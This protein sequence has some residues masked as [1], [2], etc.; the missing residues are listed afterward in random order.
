MAVSAISTPQQMTFANNPIY[1]VVD[2][3]NKGLDGFRYVVDIYYTGTSNKI[4]E[5]LIA[6]RPTDGYGEFNINQIVKNLLSQ[7]LTISNTTSHAIPNL[8][9]G[10]DVK[11]GEAYVTSWTFN[12]VEPNGA[13]ARLVQDPTS[14]A[15]S[16][17]TGDQLRVVTSPTNSTVDGLRTVL[18]RTSYTVTINAP[19]N[20]TA[21]GGLT[22]FAD[23]TKTV[24]RD[25]YTFTNLR[26]Y[27]GALDRVSFINYDDDDYT[28]STSLLGKFLTTIPRGG[29]TLSANSLCWLN[30]FA[31]SLSTSGNRVYFENSNGDVFY[32]ASG[33]GGI[34]FGAFN[35][36]HGNLPTLTTSSGTAPLIKTDTI[37]YEVWLATSGGVRTSEKIRINLSE[38]CNISDCE[39]LFMDKL[40]SFVSFPMPLRVEQ[41]G[42]VQRKVFERALPTTYTSLDGGKEVYNIEEQRRFKLNTQYLN[43]GESKYFSEVLTSPYVYMLFEGDWQPVIV[44]DSQYTTI[45]KANKNLIQYSINVSLAN[46]ENTNG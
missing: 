5:M 38:R 30:A 17:V 26:V 33:I 14:T 39:L 29:Y 2:S 6:P 18:E 36:A 9:M 7:S 10:V 23:N 44:E 42:D 37:Y 32:Y 4:A 43:D 40:G 45:R 25:L 3:T 22:Y 35:I 34:N 21:T 31:S 46:K 12:E 13:N 41:S 8:F 19:A 28:V 11:V 15:N 1:F 20:T 27:R 16:Y 24:T